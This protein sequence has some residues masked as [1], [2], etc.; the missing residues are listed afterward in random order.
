MAAAKAN[1]RKSAHTSAWDH[2]HLHRADFWRANTHL[3]AA[4]NSHTRA[5]PE[6]IKFLP[7]LAAF[8]AFK[9]FPICIM[10]VDNVLLPRLLELFLRLRKY[11]RL[12]ALFVDLT[13]TTLSCATSFAFD[14]LICLIN[15]EIVAA[16][17]DPPRDGRPL[18]FLFLNLREWIPHSAHLHLH[19]F[20]V[21]ILAKH[22]R[23]NTIGA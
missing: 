19:S 10:V 7:S 2:L 5:A 18:S 8:R 23:Q 14:W 13:F 1:L 11:L 16:A 21:E 22:C 12:C 17:L 20:C 9:C 6:W 15:S 4:K 3:H